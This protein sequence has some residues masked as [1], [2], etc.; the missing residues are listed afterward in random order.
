MPTIR[1][2]A[3]FPESGDPAGLVLTEV[4]ANA[5]DESAGEYVELYN[6]TST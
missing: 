4:M 5:V 6:P 2:A 1:A 3:C